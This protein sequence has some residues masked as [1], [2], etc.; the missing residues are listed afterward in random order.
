VQRAT[1]ATSEAKAMFSFT[2]LVSF[3]GITSL[4]DFLVR[5]VTRRLPPSVRGRGA[6]LPKPFLKRHP[7]EVRWGS[8]VSGFGIP[9]SSAGA[10]RANPW[11]EVS[12]PSTVRSY[13][14]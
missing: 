10:G 3:L 6:N 1:L 13:A 7:R 11:P 12:E 4:S 5:T 8:W 9:G 2:R 14:S